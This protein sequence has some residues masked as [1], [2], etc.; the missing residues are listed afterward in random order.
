MYPISKSPVVGNEVGSLAPARYGGLSYEVL[1]N[2]QT[3]VYTINT[4]VFGK[5]NI[6]APRDKDSSIT[7]KPIY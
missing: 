3:D 6:Y 1:G 5:V 7:D 4:S 2:P